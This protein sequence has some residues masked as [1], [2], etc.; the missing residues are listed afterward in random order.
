MAPEDIEALFRGETAHVEWKESHEAKDLLDAVCAFANDL[1]DSKRAGHVVIG[2]HARSGK[3]CG[4]YPQA[5]TNADEVQQK[6]VSLISSTK[7]IR[8]PW[9]TS[10]RWSARGTWC[11]CCASSRTRSRRW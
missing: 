6:L 9:F 10:R 11:S 5:T 4:K 2:V 7:I 8:T 3:P 1:A